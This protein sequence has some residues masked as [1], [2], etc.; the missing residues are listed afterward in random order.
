MSD[1]Y[2]TH[3]GQQ[4]GP[5]TR[6]AIGQLAATGELRPDALVWTQGMATWQP[7][8]QVDGLFPG[9]AAFP[10]PIPPQGIPMPYATP[11]PYAPYAAQ[12]RLGDD[13]GMRML[14]PVGRSGWAIAAGYLGLIS[15]LMVP[16]PF[17]LICSIVAI[18]DIKRHP[19]RH[20]MG[21]AIFGLI[22]GLIFTVL[23]ALFLLRVFV[24]SR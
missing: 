18:R 1:W 6:E 3:G 20:G 23:L 22:M 4:K 24:P 17:A 8:G 15:V 16:A 19:E 5:A 14:L 21:R 10:P 9:M 2:Y 13:A 7:A 11:A 12:P